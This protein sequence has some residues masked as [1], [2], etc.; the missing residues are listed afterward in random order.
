MADRGKVIQGL[1][2]CGQLMDCEGCPY[3]TET[4]NCFTNL[5]SDALE[6]MKEQEPV[7]PVLG[8]IGNSTNDY[9]CPVCGTDLYHYQKYCDEC[10]RKVKWNE[11]D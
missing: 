3:D 4:G 9:T 6:L 8:R 1:E 5:K 10:G 2:H 7:R 11:V